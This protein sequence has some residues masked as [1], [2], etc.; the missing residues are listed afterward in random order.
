MGVWPQVG[1]I[2]RP[3]QSSSRAPKTGRGKS[4]DRPLPPTPPSPRR[5]RSE[6]VWKARAEDVD[7]AVADRHRG[8]LLLRGRPLSRGRRAPE[9]AVAEPEEIICNKESAA[10]SPA[11]PCHPKARSATG[12]AAVHEVVPPGQEGTRMGWCSWNPPGGGDATRQGDGLQLAR[13]G[14]N[15][16]GS[17]APAFAQTRHVRGP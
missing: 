6:Q 1:R 11:A 16:S 8:L 17:Q 3:T 12:P 14:L 2:P 5:Q 15:A 13:A 4:P 7:K 9:I 10:T